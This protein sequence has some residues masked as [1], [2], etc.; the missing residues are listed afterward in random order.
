MKFVFLFFFFLSLP[1]EPNHHYDSPIYLFGFD[2]FPPT[3]TS[4]LFASF[5]SLL[6]SLSKHSF[7]FVRCLFMG[8]EESEDVGVLRGDHV[9]YED[10]RNQTPGLYII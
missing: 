5:L 6:T 1:H 3:T 2:V 8:M 7:I 4:F 10:K 9:L